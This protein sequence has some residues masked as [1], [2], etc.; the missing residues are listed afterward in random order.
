MRAW[1]WRAMLASSVLT[2]TLPP[3]YRGGS[4]AEWWWLMHTV[5]LRRAAM[6]EGGLASKG[7]QPQL[8]YGNA[9]SDPPGAELPGSLWVPNP[10]A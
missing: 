8:P 5:P 10:C 1:G 3:A 7:V 2:N 9:V 6:L 4:K